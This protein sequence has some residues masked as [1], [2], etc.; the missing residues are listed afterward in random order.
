[1]VEH[2]NCFLIKSLPVSKNTTFTVDDFNELINIVQE[3]VD[4]D[5]QAVQGKEEGGHAAN[6]GS[7][8]HKQVLRPSKIYHMLA[9]RACRQSI[10]V[11]KPLDF[12]LMSKVLSNLSSLQSP[13]NCPH[14]RPTLRYL[15]QIDQKLSCDFDLRDFI[16][17]NKILSNSAGLLPNN[18]QKP[19]KLLLNFE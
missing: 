12:K 9:S 2:S 4:K 17:E 13:W 14:G 11:G 7:F 18:R 10:M 3:H 19:P 16:H 5:E 1:M 6:N 15:R 8:I